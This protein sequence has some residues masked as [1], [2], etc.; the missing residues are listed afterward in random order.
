MTSIFLSYAR[1]D[2]EPFVRRLCDDLTIDGFEIWFDRQDLRSQGRTFLD[3]IRQ[4]ITT[5]V[6]LVLIFGSND[7]AVPDAAIS[8]K[9][10]STDSSCLVTVRT[11]KRSLVS[12]ERICL[13]TETFM[14]NVAD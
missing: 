12:K 5:C 2:D 7:A 8:G 11:R 3:E 13:I 14:E 4:A 1:A 10:L 9:K 6:R